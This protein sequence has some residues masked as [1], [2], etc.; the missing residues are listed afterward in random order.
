MR[1]LLKLLPHKA[2][3]FKANLSFNHTPTGTGNQ[4]NRFRDQ[5]KNEIENRDKQ[6][7]NG[8]KEIAPGLSIQEFIKRQQADH[9]HKVRET[10]I[11]KHE[12]ENVELVR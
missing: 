2:N 12:T 7:R 6:A 4:M 8:T 9:I 3:K 10:N 5:L 1:E 11:G